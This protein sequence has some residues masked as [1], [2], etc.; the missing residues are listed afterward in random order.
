MRLNVGVVFGGQSVEHEVSIISAIQMMEN[1]NQLVYNPIPI[2]LSKDNKYYYHEKMI[3]IEFFK[4]FKQVKQLSKEVIFHNQGQNHELLHLKGMKLR[5]LFDIDVIFLVVHGTNCED[6]TLSAYFELLDIPYVGSDLLSASVS[7]N[8]RCTKQLLKDKKLPIIDFIHFYEQEYYEDKTKCLEKCENLDYP[9]IIKPVS[10]GSSVGISKCK[11][12]SELI[13][14]LN[15]AFLYDKEVLVEKALLN[16]REFNCSVLGN[17]A[18]QQASSVEEVIQTDDILSYQ[19]KY[20]RGDK[21]SSK[22]IVSTNRIIPAPISDELKEEIQ[23]LAKQTFAIIGNSG[24]SRIDFLYDQDHDQIYINEINTIPGSLSYY[25]WKATELDYP[26]LISQLID[27]AL[28]N[29]KIKKS[30]IFSYDT[31]ILSIS[32]ANLK[33]K[34][35]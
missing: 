22:G 34:L 16:I 26:Q 8:K 20:L 1:M 12:R 21:E 29:Y 28:E 2:Y 17:Q 4:D 33:G 9:L 5:K 30:K 25:L 31:N 23:T 24:V 11:D 7:Q 32:K 15:Q 18:N 13:L 27:I 3:D 14:A 6:G 19:D 35:K 10:L